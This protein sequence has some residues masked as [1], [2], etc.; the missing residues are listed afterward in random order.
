[1]KKLE[2]MDKIEK[3]VY[4]TQPSPVIL[5]STI[6]ENG[7]LNLAPFAMF[8]H[9]SNK[10]PMIA[11]AISSKTDTYKNIKQIKE[12]VIGIPNETIIN[13]LYKAGEKV[14]SL[15]NEFEMVGLTPYDSKRLQ[16]KKIME[17]VVNLECKLEAEMK[18]GNH[19]LIVARV[20]GCDIDE[21]KWKDNKL[22]LRSNIPGIY[23]ITGNTFIVNGK[24]ETIKKE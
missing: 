8:M 22:E 4:A 6:D 11:I 24:V 16:C 17:C 1:M 19:I 21:K 10:P 20:V 9:C 12:F 7:I 14:E 13:K 15:V 2:I 23:H 18:T 3:I 5:V